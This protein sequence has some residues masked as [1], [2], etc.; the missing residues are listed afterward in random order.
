M[1]ATNPGDERAARRWGDDRALLDDDEARR[2]L[3][4]ATRRCIVRRGD[5]QIRMAEVADEAGVARSTVYRYFPTRG[6]LI[7]GVLLDRI[8][9]ALANV[10]ASLPWPDDAARSLPEFVLQPI[11]LVEGNPLNEAL[12]SAESSAFVTSLELSSEKLTDAA[13]RQLGAL[14]E[15]WQH[16]GQL[17]ADLDL[18]E[19]LHWMN[20]VA[21]FLLTPPWRQRTAAEKR[22]FLDRYLVRALVAAPGRRRGR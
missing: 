20:G 21:L 11:A 10:V 12:F 18:H 16:D 19:T 1:T 22:V 7:L 15:G 13:Y 9:V 6:D 8:E 17:H 5:A 4:E 14:M 2:R 3:I